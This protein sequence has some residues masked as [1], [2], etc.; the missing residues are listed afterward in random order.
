MSKKDNW[1]PTDSLN[2]EP[3][4]LAAVKEEK[5]TLVQA[6]PG[7]GKTEL[8][9]QKA[10][11]LFVTGIC[12][13]PSRILAVSFKKDAAI[14]LAERVSL[15][16]NSKFSKRFVSKTFDSFA[17]SLFDRFLYG[18]PEEWRP[19]KNYKIGEQYFSKACKKSGINITNSHTRKKFLDEFYITDPERLSEKAKLVWQMM[20]K[21]EEGT[22]YLTFKMISWLTLLLLKRNP[23]ITIM[24]QNTYSHVFIDEFQDTTELQYEI[25]KKCFSK[26]STKLTVVGDSKQKIMKWAGAME[27]AFKIFADDFKATSYLLS[28]NRRSNEKIQGLLLN[29]NQLPSCLENIKKLDN[30]QNYT[31]G[32]VELWTF[33]SE[34]EEAKQVALKVKTLIDNGIKPEEICLL[35]KQKVDDYMEILQQSFSEVNVPIR[36]EN[37]YHDFLKDE[38]VGIILDVLKVVLSIEKNTNWQRVFNLRLEFAGVNITNSIKQQEK[39][40]ESIH[41][42]IDS[43]SKNL[44]TVSSP[45]ELYLLLQYILNFY[46]LDNISSR[47]EGRNNNPLYL[48]KTIENLSS[49]LY[50]YYKQELDWKEAIER[51]C[52]KGIVSVMTIHKSKGLEFHTVFLIDLSGSSFYWTYRNDPEEAKALFFVAIS[53][54]KENFY[55]THTLSRNKKGQSHML[56]SQFYDVLKYSSIVEKRYYD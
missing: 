34:K 26:S 38:I 56:I 47:F 11:Y 3:E 40:I 27:D 12:S 37:K 24:I 44:N 18:L 43:V 25:I 17:K 19:Y 16:V 28:L 50:E 15:R 45:E 4:A 46:G 48:E 52:G 31:K 22:S 2:L 49:F 54:A 29:V 7:A 9:S 13:E 33:D 23:K 6:G 5:H 30:K 35:I 36:N 51:F 32:N 53:R 42:L 1:V 10:N 41:K 14:N 8:L 20:L 55:C 39:I 21:G